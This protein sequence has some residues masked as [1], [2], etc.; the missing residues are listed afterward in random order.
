V[1]ARAAA[2]AGSLALCLAAAPTAA[3]ARFAVGIVPGADHAAVVQQ[4]R[5][6]G[7]TGFV[8]LSPIPAL[9]VSAPRAAALQG[10]PGAR[11]VEPLRSRR[12][13]FEPNDPF[14]ARQWYAAQ[15]RAF[16]SWTELPPL[17]P[18]RIAVI[19]SGV[20]GTHPE[21]RGR[22][23]ASKSF[24]AGS[25]TVDTQGHGTFVAG[26]LA[27]QT[28]DGVGIAGL[29]PPAELLVAKVVGPERSIPV[30]AEAKAIRWAVASGARIINMSLGGVRD[31]GDPSRDTYSQLEADAIV[32]AVS[33]RVLVVAAV[34]NSDQ[35]PSQP[36][37]Y[38][39]WPAAL[40]HVLGVSALSRS[41][42]SPSFSNR[43]PQFNDIAAP[44]EDILSTFPL[45]LTAEHPDCLEQGYSSCGPEEYRS[46]EGTSF[47]TPQV[48]AAAAMLLATSP[49]LTPDQ[50]VALL[51]GSAVDAVPAN[52]CLACAI[53]RDRFT[54]AGRLDQVAMLDLLKAGEPPR[55][56]YEPNDD[57][58]AS[59]YPLFGRRRQVDATLDYWNDRNDVYGVF[60]RAGERLVAT[61]GASTS[62]RPAFAL[63][64]PGTQTIDQASV[65][66]RRLAARPPGVT[67]TYRARATGW[68]VLHV[69]VT[70][71]VAGPYQIVVS[72]AP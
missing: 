13:S 38:A 25:A 5:A 41:G 53:G 23:A 22:V 48:T 45:A 26:L 33:K 3:A 18:V 14:L 39:S 15:N 4:L 52:G 67:L 21:L 59:A 7:A 1:T 36:W 70:R 2:V 32:Y 43:D 62:V 71:P 66:V 29:A 60:L 56:R 68:Y 49:A 27:A 16:E 12:E 54:G 31:P 50:V 42:G 69:S 20:D 46:A 24:V 44:G 11:Y 9:V 35:S 6:Q 19:D 47:A 55:D 17:A 34:G 40:P 10:V 28:N 63:W 64:R 72:K 37:P 8:D 57:G 65:K 58:G 61:A 30:E 51:E